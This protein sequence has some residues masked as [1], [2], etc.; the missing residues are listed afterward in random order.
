M[1]LELGRQP[2]KQ[3]RLQLLANWAAARQRCHLPA[4]S[5]DRNFELGFGRRA[6][7]DGQARQFVKL[8]QGI[9]NQRVFVPA[10]QPGDPR[11][12]RP[13]QV[14]SLAPGKASVKTTSF[15]VRIHASEKAPCDDNL[16]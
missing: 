13:A 16:F 15:K 5:R 10:I 2:V 7:L 4:K 11:G 14:S 6:Q 1:R 3:L 9:M 12:C 8:L